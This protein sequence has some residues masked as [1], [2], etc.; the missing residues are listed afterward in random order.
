MSRGDGMLD[1][2]IEGA[3]LVDGTGAPSRQAP[4]GISGDRIVLPESGD[5]AVSARRRID[6]SGL[7]VSPGFVDVHTHFDAQV[8]WDPYL[9]PSSL[10]GVTTVVAGNCGFSIA[11]L[12]DSDADYML[13]L[14]ARVEG[15]PIPAL[16]EGVPW[17]WSTFG[18]YLEAVAA[19]GPAVNFGVMAGHSALRRRVLG[20]GSGAK[21]LDGETI[22]RLRRELRDA[23][24]A[25]AMGFSSSWGDAHFDGDGNPI[26]SRFA[27]EEELV[28]LCAELAE[29]PGAQV[30]FIPTIKPFTDKHIDLMARMSATADAPLNWNVLL[31]T[32]PDSCRGKLGASDYAAAH[33]ASVVALSYPGPMNARVSFLTS[34]FD[35]IPGWSE[36]MALPPDE[37]AA[38][39]SDPDQ[40]QRLK[41]LAAEGDRATFGLTRFEDLRV[42]DAYTAETKPYEGRRLGELAHELG[43][44]VFDVL[45]DLGVAD[46]RTGFSRAPIGDDSTSWDLRLQTWKDPRVVIGASDA[47]AHVDMLSTFDYAVAL[48]ALAREREALPIE[49]VVRLLTHVPASLYRMNDRGRIVDGARADVVVFDPGKVGPGRVSW[50]NDLPGGAGRLFSEPVGI[51]HVFVN[52][53]EI[54]AHGTLTGERPGRMLVRGGEAAGSTL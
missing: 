8:F 30:E 23:L 22:G 17:N 16:R 45:C 44:D 1:V 36:T 4:V 38:V 31:P 26:P 18:E 46:I 51:E 19:A 49:E 37:L 42:L 32:D 12:S 39:L 13:R 35:A 24:Q 48:L 43:R 15:I 25:G 5:G 28:Q 20:A 10:H 40:R 50:R 47:G 53:T 9:T 6:A 7:V 11:P 3:T 2:A 21:G 33:G 29:F 54:A 14:L 27:D 34:A 52:G 41:K